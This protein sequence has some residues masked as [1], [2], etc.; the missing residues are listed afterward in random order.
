MQTKEL[1][2]THEQYKCAI[3]MITKEISN[4]SAELDSIKNATNA[5]DSLDYDFTQELRIFY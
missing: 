5:I 3:T 4:I 2:N 1:M